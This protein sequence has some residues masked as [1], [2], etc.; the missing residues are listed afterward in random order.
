MV[1]LPP[2]TNVCIVLAMYNDI[3]LLAFLLR[4]ATSLLNYFIVM[5]LYI[6]DSFLKLTVWLA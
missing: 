5:S 1:V 6:Y 3:L 4:S 2:F